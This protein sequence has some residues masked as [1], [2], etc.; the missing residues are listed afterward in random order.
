M[1][2]TKVPTIA[3]HPRAPAILPWHASVA[4][5]LVS[6]V[7]PCVRVPM[8]YSTEGAPHSKFNGPQHNLS[9][10]DSLIP[11]SLILHHMYGLYLVS[12]IDTV[13]REGILVESFTLALEVP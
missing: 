1:T 7:A 4:L 12:I 2:R 3:V 8:E 9:G 13:S 6:S 11:L 5:S 10:P